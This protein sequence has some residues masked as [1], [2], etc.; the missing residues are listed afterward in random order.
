MPR[1]GQ[2]RWPGRA[3]LALA[4]S[5]LALF[6]APS[7]ALGAGPPLIG[8]TWASQVSSGSVRLSAEVNPNAFSTSYRFEYTT[9]AAYQAD[10]A[11]GGHDGFSGA[12]RQPPFGNSN[13]GLSALTVSKAATALTPATTYRYRVVATNSAGTT[14]GS[15]PPHTFTTQPPA[16]GADSCAN[17]AIRAQQFSTYLADCRAYELVSPVQKNGGQVELP[18]AIAGGGVLQAATGGGAVTYG[19]TT[20]FAGGSAA[21]GASQ[22]LA[23]R[24]GAGWSTANI[25]APVSYQ[26]TDQ[27]VPY[28]LFSADLGRALLFSGSHCAGGD[29]SVGGPPLGGTDAPSGYQ[30]Y[31][32]TDTASGAFEALLGA[33][34]LTGLVLG[35]EEFDLRFVGASADLA[36]IVI[37]TCAALSADASEVTLGPG[38]DKSA[39]NLYMTSSGQVLELIN[40]AT[41]GAALAASAGAVSA[42]GQRVYW[43]DTSN[44]E[45]HLNDGGTDKLL[46]A[47]AA[48]FQAASADGARALYTKAAH[49][50]RYDAPAA[51]STDLTPAGGVVGVLGAS[52][53]TDYV[54]YQDTAGLKLHH[55]GNVTQVAPN[56]AAPPAPA[57]APENFSPA[58]GTA[59]VSADGTK[60]LFSSTAALTG[61][62]NTDLT[63]GNADSELFL[64][65]ATAPSLTCVSCNPTNARPIGSASVPGAVPNGS[66]LGSTEVYKPRV[67]A[68][69]GRRVFFDS[70]DA[71]ALTDTNSDSLSGAGIVDAYQWRAAGEGGCPRPSGCISLLSSGRSSE[72]ARF[73]DA[74]ADGTDAFFIT[75]ESLLG[76]DPGSQDL[77]GARAGGGFFVP[78]PPIPCEGDACQVI[79][80]EPVDPTLT[81]VLAGHGNPP[82]HYYKLNRLKKGNKANK[83]KGKGSQGKK[84]H[85]RGKKGRGK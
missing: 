57:A 55:A 49:L 22:Y 60:L 13:L 10:L 25:T 5:S 73:I 36:Q 1:E 76:A 4:L 2:V 35:P 29:C 53:N 70:L 74:S 34:D 54:Y 31:Y 85:K 52:A 44:G 21:P 56:Q 37:S 78:S 40:N 46:S 65:D 59:R 43:N 61:Y 58:T 38:C 7:A 45:L 68:A 79:P 67:L 71:L 81:T 30:N 24:S 83:G 15:T 11:I 14:T 9:E 12:L 51:Q 26:A 39:Q 33:E 23:T 72:G 62:D 17:K 80:P 75:A 41:P 64:Y 32:L 19:S 6:A 82:I 66:A 42:D 16:G 20:S 77:Y 8:A 18:G 47:G 84:H 63:T 48:S 27:G 50:Y 3:S 28:E 69:D